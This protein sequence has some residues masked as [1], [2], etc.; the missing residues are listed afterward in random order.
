MMSMFEIYRSKEKAIYP[1]SDF[2]NKCLSILQ[3][4]ERNDEEWIEAGEKAPTRQVMIDILVGRTKLTNYL[5]KKSLAKGLGYNSVKE[6]MGDES[7]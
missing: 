3:N 5:W 2:I 6:M 4:D 1:K 7:N